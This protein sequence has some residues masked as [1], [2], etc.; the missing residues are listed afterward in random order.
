MENQILREKKIISEKLKN[1]GLADFEYNPDKRANNIYHSN[2]NEEEENGP[3]GNPVNDEM[4]NPINP[5][6]KKKFELAD[7]YIRLCKDHGISPMTSSELKKIKIT[8]LENENI[9]INK[10]PSAIPQ[11]P[12]QE[13][14]HEI[15]G[16]GF[17][18]LNKTIGGA[19]ECSSP[20]LEGFQSKIE[21][22]E[23]HFIELGKHL[24][25]NAQ[26]SEAMGHITN[27]YVLIISLYGDLIAETVIENKKKNLKKV[28][29]E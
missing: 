13:D 25:K 8:D 17:Y 27:P 24:S 14:F 3:P 20:A 1:G 11:T 4:P 2:D 19:I 5:K 15:R 10:L 29:E 23:K 26:T 21:K 9:R 16:E 22:R 18:M 12:E 6:F 28:A 7:E